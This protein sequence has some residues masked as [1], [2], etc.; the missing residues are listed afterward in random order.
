MGIL[1]YIKIGAAAL[2]ILFVGYL[3]VGK[4][5]AESRA[6]VAESAVAQRDAQIETLVGAAKAQRELDAWLDADRKASAEIAE[7]ADSKKKNVA[8][9]VT[10]NKGKVKDES[11]TEKDGPAAHVL[12]DAVTAL[13]GLYR[14]EIVRACDGGEAD[15]SAVRDSAGAS[16]CTSIATLIPE[17]VWQSDAAMVSL[18]FGQAY[19]DCAIQLEAIKERVTLQNAKVDAFNARTSP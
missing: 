4:K 15:T 6:T 7:K 16:A 8:A 10:I 14:T 12:V 11:K 1:S 18:R 17:P 2:L 9:V 3:Y 19:T 13:R 5:S